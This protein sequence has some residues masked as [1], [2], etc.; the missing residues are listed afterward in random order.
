MKTKL[1]QF[2][3]FLSLSLFAV[4]CPFPGFVDNGKVLLVGSMGLYEY[5]PYVRKIRNNRQIMYQCNRGHIL[6]GGP[7]GATCIDGMWSPPQLPR[8]VIEKIIAFEMFLSVRG[9]CNC[10]LCTFTKASI[11]E[12]CRRPQQQSLTFHPVG[13]GTICL[14]Q[15]FF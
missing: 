1:G 15:C 9:Q 8:Y 2:C 10:R 7:T 14:G 3:L 5:R 6:V 13:G 4:F 12:L 11:F